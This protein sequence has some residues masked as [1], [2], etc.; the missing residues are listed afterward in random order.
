MGYG[1]HGLA[2]SFNRLVLSRAFPVLAGKGF[3]LTPWRD[4][5]RSRGFPPE[6]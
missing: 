4:D 3:A 6:V 5:A 2:R 1:E